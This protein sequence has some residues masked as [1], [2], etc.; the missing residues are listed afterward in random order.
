MEGDSWRDTVHAVRDGECVML[1]HIK[2]TLPG[3]VKVIVPVESQRDFTNEERI[4]EEA[5]WAS[6]AGPVACRYAS[7]D[8]IERMIGRG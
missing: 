8:E 7:A 3:G 1:Q 5:E 2:H 4:R 6:M